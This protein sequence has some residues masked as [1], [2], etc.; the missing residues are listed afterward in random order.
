VKRWKV[1]A[2]AAVAAAIVL[3]PALPA[4]AD[5]TNDN[6]DQ[7]RVKDGN[8]PTEN[9]AENPNWYRESTTL[10]STA[11]VYKANDPGDFTGATPAPTG[12]GTGALALTTNH[13]GTAQA[14]LFTTQY[15]A[16]APLADLTAIDYWT[17]QDTDSQSA[18]ALP[19]LNV[20]VI[21]GGAFTTLVYEP[22]LELPGGPSQPITPETWQQWFAS[23]KRW[24]STRPITCDDFE[25]GPGPANGFT[26]PSEVAAE[27]PGAFILQIGVNIGSGSPN[28]ITAVDGLHITL[29]ADDHTW[30]FGR[31]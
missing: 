27:C 12:L 21:A 19:A 30:N 14:Q 9:A 6:V 17:Y 18:V 23:D 26:S 25:V 22:Y 4:S 7:N 5:V 10:G 2:G 11:Q 29:G 1:V 16:G 24:W 3:G 28:S 15:V 20:Q 8:P 31:K 13:L